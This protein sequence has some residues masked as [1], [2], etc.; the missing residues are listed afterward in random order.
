MVTILLEYQI[1]VHAKIFFNAQKCDIPYFSLQLS[2][3]G[4]FFMEYRH[5]IPFHQVDTISIDGKVEIS[6]IGFLNAMVRMLAK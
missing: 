6:S 4:C 5:R 1:F 3:N 2:V